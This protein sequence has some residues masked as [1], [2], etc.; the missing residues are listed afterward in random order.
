AAVTHFN[1]H[2]CSFPPSLVQGCRVLADAH[3]AQG[4]FAQS[5]E[6]FEEVCKVADGL[7]Q[8]EPGHAGAILLEKAHALV[9]WGNSLLSLGLWREALDRYEQAR[10]LYQEH[11]SLDPARVPQ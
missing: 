8:E 4:H 5:H 3:A 10:D 7:S 6:W 2:G 9:S 11:A 1:D